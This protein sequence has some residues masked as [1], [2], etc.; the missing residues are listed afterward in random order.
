MPLVDV[1]V[2]AYGKPYQTAVSILSLLKYSGQHIDKIWLR[3]ELQHPHGDTFDKILKWLPADK[4]IHHKPTFIFGQGDYD[5]KRL[6]EPEYRQSIWGQLAWEKTDKEFIFFMHND[7]KFD[8][9][10][11]GDL[12][13]NIGDAV[14]IGV[15]GCCHNCPVFHAKLCDHDTWESYKPTYEQAIATIREYPTMRMA[16][17]HWIAEVDRVSPMPLPECCLVESAALINVAK[18]KHLVVPIGNV[19]P[20]GFVHMDGCKDWFRGIVL[21]GCK[22]QNYTPKRNHGWA[23]YPNWSAGYPMYTNRD[24]YYQAE[25]VAKQYLEEEF[26]IKE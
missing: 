7:V 11:I 18:T 24:R 17:A 5:P 25:A 8:E 15:V 26:G 12:L 16:M 4:I 13:T 20:Y 14:G 22:V 21:A 2:G 1:V 3:E 19:H 23:T 10:C 6:I 9:D